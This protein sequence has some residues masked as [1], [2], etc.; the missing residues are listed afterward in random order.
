MPVRTPTPD[1]VVSPLQYAVAWNCMR[2]P[3]CGRMPVS[4]TVVAVASERESRVAVC[5]KNTNTSATTNVAI[6]FRK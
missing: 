3:A 6:A 4:T 2:A 1:A 5:W